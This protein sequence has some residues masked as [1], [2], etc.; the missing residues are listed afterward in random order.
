MALLACLWQGR[1][2]AAMP[3]SLTFTIYPEGE[4]I[5]F[6]L[7]QRTLA[8]V[9]RLIER[10][11]YV[12]THETLGRRWIVS[13]LHSSAP[14][15]TVQPLIDPRGVVDKVADGLRIVSLGETVVPP[16]Y[17]SVDA[18]QDLRSMRGLFTSRERLTHLD[19]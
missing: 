10:V 5:S 14:T 16:P 18:L 17:Y 9:R 7:L 3:E 8:R 13:D 6:A 11:D 19:F 15:I 1:R 12:V 4:H 2:G